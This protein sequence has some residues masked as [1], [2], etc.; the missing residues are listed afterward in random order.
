MMLVRICLLII[1]VNKSQEYRI[2]LSSAQTKSS[3]LAIAGL[4]QELASK[5]HD[6]YLLAREGLPLPESIESQMTVIRYGDPERKILGDALMESTPSIFETE[7]T[8]GSLRGIRFLPSPRSVMPS[9]LKI[10]SFTTT[11]LS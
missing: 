3:I 7:E 6:V 8:F 1:V 11:F 5:G 2:L 4:G 10:T 9:C